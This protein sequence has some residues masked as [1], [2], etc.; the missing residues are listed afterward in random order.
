MPLSLSQILIHLV[1]G[2]K[3]RANWITLEIEGE[4]QKYVTVV[5][6]RLG[7]APL[8]VGGTENHIHILCSLPRTMTVSKLVERIK[9]G[10]AKWVKTN[11]QDFTKFA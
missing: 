3:N 7:S 6:Q 9:T 4:F 2:T 1:F 11:G 5:C 8:A 10:T